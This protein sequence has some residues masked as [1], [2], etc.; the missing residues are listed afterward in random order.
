MFGLGY[1]DGLVL[2]HV[3]RSE[4]HVDFAG[5]FACPWWLFCCMHCQSLLA[6]ALI[7]LSLVE[8]FGLILCISWRETFENLHRLYVKV[9]LGRSFW[10]LQPTVKQITGSRTWLPMAH[11]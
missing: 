5:F 2:L 3:L 9:C 4:V 8:T 1:A 7:G 10:T 6:H 11:L